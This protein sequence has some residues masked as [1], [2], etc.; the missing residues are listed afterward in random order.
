[1]TDNQLGPLALLA[2]T[3]EGDRGNDIAP[4]ADLGVMETAF[5]ER[6]VFEPIG[7]VTNHQQSLYGLRYATTV[8][9][10]GDDEPF[11]EEVGYWLWDAANRQ[12]MRSFTVPRGYTVLAG[13]TAT[14]DASR[15]EIVA[16]VGSETYGICSNQFLEREFR[17]VRFECSMTIHDADSFTYEEDTQI[18]IRGQAD[19]FHHRDNNRLVRAA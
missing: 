10:A 12:V 7:E 1:M 19:L 3:W 9:P 2:G 18:R 13:G 17:T 6:M 11:H 4:A 5:R 8:W 15:F 16:D 14:A